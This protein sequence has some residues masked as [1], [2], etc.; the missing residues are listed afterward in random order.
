MKIVTVKK[1]TDLSNFVSFTKNF[2]HRYLINLF[3]GTKVHK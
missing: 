2:N 1:Q 3:V